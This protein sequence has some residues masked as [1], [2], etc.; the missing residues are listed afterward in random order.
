ARKHY[1]VN[2]PIQFGLVFLYPG[3]FGSGKVAWRIQVGSQAQIVTYGFE[4]FLTY[5][6]GAAVAPDDGISKHLLLPVDQYQSVH[7]VGN[8]YCLNLFRI[9][10][11]LC[12]SL[13]NAFLYM[14]PP[15]IG[16]LFCPSGFFCN[17]LD[18]GFRILNGY[19]GFLAG[20]V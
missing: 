15:L 2:S 18:L 7:L 5:F 14:K 17:N 11:A 19:Q 8:A 10:C 1:L 4:S 12:M 16:R 6:D 3:E 9:V 13:E 20:P